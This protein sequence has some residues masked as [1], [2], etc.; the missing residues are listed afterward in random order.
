MCFHFGSPYIKQKQIN[1]TY[2]LFFY[3]FV[4]NNKTKEYHSKDLKKIP[5]D[6][7][8][9]KKSKIY[10]YKTYRMKHLKKKLLAKKLI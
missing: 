9:K 1:N 10:V 5:F 8:K 7:V 2:F 6:K 3:S 4:P